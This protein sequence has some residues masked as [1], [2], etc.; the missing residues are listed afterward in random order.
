[1]AKR[2]IISLEA[3]VKFI[4]VFLIAIVGL[5]VLATLWGV[6][7]KEEM[8]AAQ[9]DMQ[10]VIQNIKTLSPGESIQVFTRAKDANLVF[11]EN[12][13]QAAEPSCAGQTC[14]C[15]YEPK[16]KVF[17]VTKCEA[18]PEITK[19]C[20]KAEEADAKSCFPGPTEK[21]QIFNGQADEK[22]VS[23]VVKI[24]KRDGR[25]SITC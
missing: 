6:F 11:Y 4:P 21:V 24:C 22:L 23:T 19:E 20:P 9:Y 14:I 10:R 15:V 2:G 1:M 7:W 8:S 17:A 25:I 13:A 3:L 16:N 12:G 5:F 18:F